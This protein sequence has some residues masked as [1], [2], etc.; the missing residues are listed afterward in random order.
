M[1][2][3]TRCYLLVLI[4]L[5]VGCTPAPETEYSETGREL[6][7]LDPENGLDE[8]WEQ[9]G[10]GRGQTT[11]EQSKASLGTTIRATGNHSASILY[12]VFEGIDLSCG[13]LQ[14]DWFVAKLQTTSNLRQKGRDDVG[15]SI[16]VSFGDPG[17]FR[18]IPV[19]ILKYVW[20]NEKHSKNDIIIGPY[21]TRYVRTIIVRT[22]AATGNSLVRETRELVRDYQEAFG[23]PPDDKI[24]AIGLFTDNDDTREPI[25]AHYGPVVLI[26]NDRSGLSQSS[27]L[28][29]VDNNGEHFPVGTGELAT[30]KIQPLLLLPVF[31]ILLSNKS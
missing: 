22:G 28:K 12:R 17:A 15:A 20:A 4:V 10:F 5:M 16:L 29:K 18:D 24:H 6:V 27:S 13:R 1:K 14:W 21:Q 25:T 11:Y 7:L 19:P 9:L 23:E 8:N 30:G 26:C 2:M 3:V 31:P